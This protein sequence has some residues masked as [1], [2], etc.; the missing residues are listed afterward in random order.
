MS[1]QTIASI[2]AIEADPSVMRLMTAPASGF[3]NMVTQGLEQV[4]SQLMQSQTT[5]Q[6]LALGETQNLH[7]TMIQ[8]EETR[9]ALQLILQ[10]RSRLLEAYQDVMKMS[11]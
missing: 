11:I 2:A 9:T 4:N 3:G 10:V 6:S 8:M 1:P 7:Q 5:L